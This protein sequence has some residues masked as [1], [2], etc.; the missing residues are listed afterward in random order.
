[1]KMKF[2]A[3]KLLLFATL[4]LGI[5]FMYIFFTPEKIFTQEK[6]FKTL[7]HPLVSDLAYNVSQARNSL[8]K[9]GNIVHFTYWFK[10][11]NLTQFSLTIDPAD[12]SVMNDALPEKKFSGTLEEE[13][14][15][16]VKAHFEAG[17]YFSEVEVRYRGVTGGHR[18]NSQRSLLVKF[19]K[20]NLFRGMKSM[21]LVIPQDRA[22]LIELLNATRLS[23]AGLT[24]KNIFFSRVDINNKDA[25]VYLASDRYSIEWLEIREFPSSSEVF[26]QSSDLRETQDGFL[27]S[28]H[29]YVHEED[30]NYDALEALFLI[31]ENMSDETALELMDVILDKQKWYSAMALNILAGDAHSMGLSLNI[32][33][34]TATGRFEPSLEDIHIYPANMYDEEDIYNSFTDPISKRVLSSQNLYSEFT[35][36][37]AENA[38]DKNLQQDLAYYDDLIDKYLPEFYSDQTKNRGDAY[39][40]NYIKNARKYIEENYARAQRI[41]QISAAP[42]LSKSYTDPVPPLPRSFE[43]LYDAILT[44]HEFTNNHPEFALKD[45]S[46]V[47]PGGTYTFSKNIIIPKNTNLI[48]EAGTKIYLSGGVSLIS[49]SPVSALGSKNNP[50]FVGRKNVDENWGAIA[51]IN[52]AGKNEFRYVTMVGGSSSYP[53]NGVIFTGMLSAHNAPLYVYDSQFY[54]DGDDDMINAKYST[55]EIT[56]S[57]FFDSSGDAIDLDTTNGFLL[58]SNYFSNIG[59]G[60]QGGDA[61][62]ISFSDSRILNNTI[63]GCSDKGVSAG[64]KSYPVIERNNISGCAMGIAV[65]DQS[66]AAISHNTIEKNGIGIS[67][68]QKK[69]IFTGATAQLTANNFINN[70]KEIETDEKSKILTP[71]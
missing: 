5:I 3:K 68:Y 9:L 49:Y 13:N 65:K 48:I 44:P 33:F 34:N 64:E 24:G 22:Y 26:L 2:N 21:D 69:Q 38:S 47:L 50:I 46:I 70:G 41:S 61:I 67:L 42:L 11:T 10:E 40:A 1:M 27:A 14:K 57:Q 52:T 62:D 8:I 19:P 30:R 59:T 43:Y 58:D 6:L 12:L 25:G 20:E 32:L 39:V 16:F 55:G 23:R 17:D 71:K 31:Y 56:R 29:K 63:N 45:N 51:L 54:K 28:W 7:E 37:L 35:K 60:P 18:I 4:L 66:E 15:K 36:I 53:I